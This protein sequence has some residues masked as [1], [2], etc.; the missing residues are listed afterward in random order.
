MSNFQEDAA[1][2]YSPEVSSE[3]SSPI[4]YA[5][6]SHEQELMSI[7]GVEGVGIGRDSIG[8]DAIIVYVRSKDAKKRIPHNIAGY[9]VE[10]KVTGIIDAQ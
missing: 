4:Q 5:K 9:P 3:T 8:N 6:E 1:M 10:M 7:E 2:P